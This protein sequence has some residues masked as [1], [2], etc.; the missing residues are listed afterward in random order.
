MKSIASSKLKVNNELREI[1]FTIV[2][3]CEI[4]VY[5]APNVF[6]TVSYHGASYQVP[7]Y[8]EDLMVT[9]RNVEAYA[10]RDRKRRKRSIDIQ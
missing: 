1:M 4:Y 10:H 9:V 7:S 5:S 8:R 2:D 6:Y 3:T